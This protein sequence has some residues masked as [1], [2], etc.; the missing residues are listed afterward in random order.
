MSAKLADRPTAPYATAPRSERP[1]GIDRP[2]ATTI[3]SM[4][5][6]ASENRSAALQNGVSSP[7]VCFDG[8]DHVMAGSD[9]PRATEFLAHYP[10][11]K[12]RAEKLTMRPRW[13]RMG[14]VSRP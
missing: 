5:T 12:A 13:S 3:T 10:E 9:L 11:T 1:R 7:S 6:A 4:I 14:N 2:V 8:E